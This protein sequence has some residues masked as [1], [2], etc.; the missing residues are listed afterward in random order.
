MGVEPAA[1]KL[2]AIHQAAL[3]ILAELGLRL[4][5]PEV[6]QR[7]ADVG[8]RVEGDR[9]HFPP[10][11][12][13]ELVA[14]A[15]A[16]FILHARD[17]RRDM[18]IGGGS[19]VCG[20]GYGAPAVVAADGR[21]RPAHLEDYLTFLQLIHAA[22]GL[23]LNGGVPVQPADLPAASAGAIMFFAAL[24][25]TDKPL[26]GLPGRA[27]QVQRQM[28]LAALAF[29]GA[30]ALQST[31]HVLTL[32]NT[33]SPLQLDALALETMAVCAAWGQPLILSPGPMAG[34]TGPVTLAGNLALA[35]AEALAA[36]AVCQALRPG[37][38]V[39]YGLQPTTADMRTG[40]V[41]I[42]S[43]GFAL[44]SLYGARLARRQ[45]LP[46]RGGGAGTDA[47]Q[48]TA[49]SGWES[50]L[51]L[52]VSRQAGLDVILHAAGIL[53]GYGA[54][55]YEKFV[56]DLEMLGMLAYFEDDLP[57]DADSLALETIAAVG[58]GGQYLTRPHTLAH[59]RRAPWRPT[60]AP[61]GAGDGQDAQRLLLEAAG[62]RRA[63]LQTGYVRPPMDPALEAELEDYLRA[64]GCPPELLARAALR[65]TPPH[66]A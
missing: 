64:Q 30:Q 8:L 46:C 39:V 59:C 24:L 34:A 1:A 61:A 37:L 66:A 4:H 60:L 26:L 56:F 6:R 10:E 41:C 57:V 32:V 52:A 54:M 42:G 15:P 33:L 22:E 27:P 3:R 25:A 47:P 23:Q 58:P 40:A 53:A 65:G 28:E 51:A 11:T 16:R 35:H 43:P 18:V 29:G 21:R 45:G 55:S 48:A 36:V 12:L 49:Q 13:L 17:P 2:D 38:P 63:A 5:H 7:L 9:V 44:Q 20:A 50:M 62:R 14:R 31:P 19:P